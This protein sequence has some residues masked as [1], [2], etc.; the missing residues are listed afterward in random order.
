MLI[1]AFGSTHAILRVAV[2]IIISTLSVRLCEGLA[3]CLTGS[4]GLQDG[5]G[6]CHR[7]QAGTEEEVSDHLEN[8]FIIIKI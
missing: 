4:K 6:V 2:R 8:L 7:E 5:D 1:P 3:P